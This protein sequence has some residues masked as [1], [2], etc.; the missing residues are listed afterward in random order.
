VALSSKHPEV[1]RL[2]RELALE[3]GGGLTEAVIV[4][5]RLA[6]TRKAHQT[7]LAAEILR[8]GRDCAAFPILDP[9]TPDEILDYGPDGLPR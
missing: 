6:R 7:G 2:A 1:D 3:T 9:R 8:I 4:A 5:L